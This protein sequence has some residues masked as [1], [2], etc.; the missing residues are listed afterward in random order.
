MNSSYLITATIGFF[1]Y[2][3]WITGNGIKMEFG[4]T[5]LRLFGRT[6]QLKN[7]RKQFNGQRKDL[8]Q[9]RPEQRPE[10]N[11]LAVSTGEIHLDCDFN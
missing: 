2:V 3:S 9:S 8:D 1:N 5:Y 11:H 4:L 10:T 6:K 7:F